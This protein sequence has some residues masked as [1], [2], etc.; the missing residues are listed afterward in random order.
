MTTGA[1]GRKAATQIAGAVAET[2]GE[3]AGET[4]TT[5]IGTVGVVTMEI[6]GTNIKTNGEA[7]RSDAGVT[8]RVSPDGTMM[9]AMIT[10]DGTQI[11]AM[12]ETAVVIMTDTT[13]GIETVADGSSISASTHE[14]KPSLDGFFHFFSY[15]INRMA[16]VLKES[17]GQ[18]VNAAPLIRYRR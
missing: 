10:G 1:E 17:E 11:A 12:I 5:T 6:A 13:N 8:S 16:H 7:T 9:T 15:P 4:T 2:I 18:L 14:K 3:T